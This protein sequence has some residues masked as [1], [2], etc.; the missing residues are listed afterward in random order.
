VC[1]AIA[2]FQHKNVKIAVRT[3]PPDDEQKVLEIFR[4]Y[5]SK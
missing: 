5:K 4:G 1:T 2:D 3:V